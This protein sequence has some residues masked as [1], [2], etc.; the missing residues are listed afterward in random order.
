MTPNNSSFPSNESTRHGNLSAKTHGDFL[1]CPPFPNV[2]FESLDSSLPDFVNAALNVPLAVATTVANL[3]VL[4]ASKLLLCSL[5]IT[6]LGAGSVA[7][8][9]FNAFPFFWAICPDIV[10][11][12]LFRSITVTGSVF[13]NASLLSLAAISLDRYAFLFFWAICPDI[14]QCPLF[15]SITVTGSV[16]T[17]ASLLSLAAISLDRYAFLFFWAI[18]PDIV[19][20]PLYRSITVTGS[21][22]TTAS[23]LSLAAISLDR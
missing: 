4:L 11:C 14:V 2:R 18:C 15:R 6:D 17:T 12:P 16:F 10:Q 7:A 21:A 23:L 3:V 13:T 5:V 19:Q 22:F 20:C 9:Q 8:P 1:L